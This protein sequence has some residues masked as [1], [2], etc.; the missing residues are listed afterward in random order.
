MFFDNLNGDA[1]CV[2]QDACCA[3]PDGASE[4]ACGSAAIGFGGRPA[5]V[6]AVRIPTYRDAL[7]LR[8]FGIVWGYLQSFGV[9]GLF[10]DKK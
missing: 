5:S 6:S 9:F 10:R 1:R 4:S 2:I 8:A 3:G 7:P